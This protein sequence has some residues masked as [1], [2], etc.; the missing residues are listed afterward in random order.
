MAVESKKTPHTWQ[1]ILALILIWS[2][3]IGI[4]GYALYYKWNNPDS[5]EPDIEHR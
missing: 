5:F 3:M 2:M 1:S 4:G